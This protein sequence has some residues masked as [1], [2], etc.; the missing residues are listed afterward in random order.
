M[1]V[2]RFFF[3]T[4]VAAIA[5]AAA[6]TSCQ[7]DDNEDNGKV[8][9]YNVKFDSKGGSLVAE[10][11][12]KQGDKV[13]EPPVPTR[14][15]FDFAGWTTADNATSSLWN[16]ATET[17]TEDITLYARWICVIC[18]ERNCEAEHVQCPFCREWDCDKSHSLFVSIMTV[19][20]I[21]LPDLYSWVNAM[22]AC[23]EGWRLPDRAELLFLYNNRESIGGFNGD[24]YWTSETEDETQEWAYYRQFSNGSD[25][26]GRNIPNNRYHVRCVCDNE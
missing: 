16:F 4:A 21:D 17:V 25:G 10:Q 3:I 12:V 1:I 26:L 23:P 11:K 20:D 14:E 22:T 7:K 9:T 8:I 18:R 13:Q 24:Y 6:F 15:S 19:A 5:V 2:K